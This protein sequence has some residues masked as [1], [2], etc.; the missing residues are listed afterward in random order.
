MSIYSILDLHVYRTEERCVHLDLCIFRSN[1]VF[2]FIT[3]CLNNA[4][5][6]AMKLCIV[7]SQSRLPLV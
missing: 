1:V 5:N 2:D 7:Y 6:D 3:V 4:V